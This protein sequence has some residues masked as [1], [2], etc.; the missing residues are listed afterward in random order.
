[1]NI[2]NVLV[3]LP[4]V[5]CG[6]PSIEEVP[7]GAD[8]TLH[9]EQSSDSLRKKKNKTAAV[10][11]EKREQ[12]LRTANALR[13]LD[14]NGVEKY[15]AKHID[16]LPSGEFIAVIINEEHSGEHCADCISYSLEALLPSSEDITQVI[17]LQD[18]EAGGIMGGTRTK[19]YGP[20]ELVNVVEATES[21]HGTT[22]TVQ[23]GDLLV[24]ELAANP[25]TGYDWHVTRTTRSFGYPTATFVSESEAAGG[26]GATVLTWDTSSPFVSS[27]TTTEIEVQYMRDWEDCPPQKTVAF[28]VVVE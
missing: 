15:K 26:G 10:S 3:L 27:G 28:T 24:L 2:K 11:E 7:T 23:K 4:L 6:V 9:V 5:A 17:Y 22:L 8:S 21:V 1:M 25:T 13:E 20:F 14:E 19:F 16:E 12:V 18:S